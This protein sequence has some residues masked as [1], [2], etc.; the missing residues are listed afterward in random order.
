MSYGAPVGTPPDFA[1]GIS[2]C[3]LDAGDLNKFIMVGF[4]FSHSNV[5][6]PTGTYNINPNANGYFYSDINV[7]QNSL[8]IVSNHW[9]NWESYHLISGTFTITR[10][11]KPWK[12]RID[13]DAI[14][15]N[16][17]VIKGCYDGGGYYS[18]D[19]D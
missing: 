13:V 3:Q 8:I 7:Y 16:G 2:F 12:F 4:L 14:A 9:Y 18:S 15:E 19:Y 6:D 11:N 10:V 17:W 1:D 5:N